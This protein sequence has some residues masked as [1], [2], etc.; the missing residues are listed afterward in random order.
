[1]KRQILAITQKELSSYFGSPL[2][3]IFLGTF[4]AA[5][6]FIFFSIETFFARGIADIR[7]LFRWMP[8]LLIFLLAALTMRQW[9]EEQR[10]GS[11]ELLLT[12]PVPMSSLVLGKFLAVMTLIT[13][14]LALTLPLPITVN[15]LGN[16]DWGPVIGGYLAALLMA[17]AYAAIGLFVSSRTDNQIVALIATVLLGGLFYVL[18]TRGV[19]DFVGGPLSELLWAVGTGSRFES[20]QRGVIDLRDLAYYLSITALF[21]TLNAVSLD[22]MRWSH[23]QTAY[24]RR[25]RLTTA[26]IAVNLVLLNVWLFPLRGL[27]LDLT[28]SREYS[29]STT[30]QELFTTLQ[31]PLTIRAYV[32]E[33]THP[34]LAPL[35]PQVRD[36]LREY[37]IASNGRIS[38]EMIDPSSDPEIEAEANQSYGIQP[39]ALQTSGRYQASIINAYFDLLI[40]YGD[41]SVVLNFQD[42]VE[43]ERLPDGAT[44]LRLRNL[45]YDLTRGIKRVLFGF[46]NVDSVLAA[47]D[48]PVELTLFITPNTLPAEL[49]DRVATARS[50]AQEIASGA[51]GKLI[52]TAVDV[53][54][55]ASGVTRQDL[56]EQLG[57]RPFPVDLFGTQTYYAHMLLRNGDQGQIMYPTGAQTEAEVRM[58]IESAL[59]RTASGFLKVAGI[60]TPP[61][62][63][64][65]DPTAGAMQRVSSYNLVAEQLRQEYTVRP[66]DLATGQVASDVDVLVL[67]EPQNLT[68]VELFAIDQYLM[69]GGS[70]IVAASSYQLV[71]DNF[72]G[73]LALAPMVGGAQE[74]L[75]HYGINVPTELVLDE[76]NALYPVLT[77]R[78]VGGFQVQEIQ[79]IDYPLF[80]DVR[81]DGMGDGNPIVSNLPAVTMSYVSPVV[82]DEGKNEGRETAVLL[83]SSPRSWTTTDSTIQPNFDIY[84][85]LG[86]PITAGQQSYPLAVA[87]QG[88]FESYFANRENPF[89]ASA[90]VETGEL[91]A[92]VPLTT[93]TRSPAAARLIVI[94]SSTF[95]DD[96]SLN[97]SARIAGDLYLNNLQFLQNSVDWAVEDLDLLAIR[98]RGRAARVLQPLTAG[99]QSFWEI[100]NY[101]VA[102]L[103][104]IGVYASWRTRRRSER[105]M[106]LWEEAA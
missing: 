80:V 87:I 40:R 49:N 3:I 2:A 6:L 62:Q 92:N 79:A 38:A 60:W 33:N 96:F 22:A 4:L 8:I 46:Q 94:G 57:L 1:M 39:M 29:L 83:Q 69:R 24:R 36:M 72:Q 44:E 64:P 89:L 58:M 103:A 81:P 17:A 70:V 35:I 53:D 43:F 18:G 54:D 13:L 10:S 61:P 67:L 75:D 85:G 99:E 31:E 48:E 98:V 47:L 26:L 76:Q 19:T 84:P 56:L 5:V 23:Q 73:T 20:I 37:E 82:L 7:P 52:F 55:P 77:A 51:N 15:L 14:A 42:L 65:N 34:L 97:L 93:I 21:L 25:I 95:A 16:L 100:A 102:L 45:E 28:A 88:V 9:S 27:R 11:Q 105:P 59:K 91:P 30:T 32:S 12:L 74:L 104:L 78:N 106:T 101:A 68:E 86:F 90:N 66:V 41:Q 50:V 63:N 71:Y